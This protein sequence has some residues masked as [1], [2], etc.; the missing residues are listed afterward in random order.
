MSTFIKYT[1]RY[2]L[3]NISKALIRLHRVGFIY[4]KVKSKKMCKS[5]DAFERNT[6]FF[7]L[8]KVEDTCWRKINFYTSFRKC[9]NLVFSTSCYKKL[10]LRGLRKLV[11]HFF[12][13]CYLLTENTTE[14]I[15]EWKNEAKANFCRPKRIS[16]LEFVFNISKPWFL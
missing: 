2:Y 8:T 9:K 3:G 1:G 7:H 5:Q 4:E 12:L 10:I 6:C 13:S 15:N 16:K 11:K 14:P